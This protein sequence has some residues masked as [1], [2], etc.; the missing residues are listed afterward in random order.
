MSSE[1]IGSGPRPTA[2]CAA[3][4]LAVGSRR[5][6]AAIVMGLCPAG[7]AIAGT[8]DATASNFEGRWVAEGSNLTLDLSRCKEGWCGVEVTGGNCGRTALRLTAADPE[9][10]PHDRV[11]FVGRFE[12]VAETQ[13]YVVQAY[14]VQNAPAVKLKLVG[15]SGD[16]FEMWRRTF[17]LSMLLARSGEAQCRPDSKVS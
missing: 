6:L 1:I 14:I 5:L 16:Q 3:S 10:R 11:Q 2:R 15:H 8:I 9:K 17:P 12:R 4:S 7:T 13:P